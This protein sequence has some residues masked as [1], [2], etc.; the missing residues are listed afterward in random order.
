M[1]YVLLL[2]ALLALVGCLLDDWEEEVP[3]YTVHFNVIGN[4]KVLQSIGSDFYENEIEGDS[5]EIWEWHHPNNQPK[6]IFAADSGFT[7]DSVI[8]DGSTIGS[9]AYFE[10]DMEDH[11]PQRNITIHFGE[12]C[13]PKMRFI[14]AKGS[15]FTMG[16]T[17][18][19]QSVPLHEV[20][21][22]Y[23]FWM[24][25]TVITRKEYD[26]LIRAHYKEYRTYKTAVGTFLSAR[27]NWYSA[28]LYCNTRS[29]AAGLDTVYTFSSITGTIGL[30]LMLHD[31]E[32]DETIKGYRLP[33][34]GE[35]EYACR[36]GTT[37]SFFWGMDFEWYAPFDTIEVQRYTLWDQ[38]ELY[39]QGV[40]T[41]L[42]NDFG[43]YGM[44]F[45]G[46]WCNNIYTMYGADPQVGDTLIT[47]RGGAEIP[48]YCSGY[49]AGCSSDRYKG[50]RVVLQE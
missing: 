22:D 45:R 36:A 50:F 32:Y 26:E 21:F 34:E 38:P 46:E 33:L 35:W 30:D 49:R 13:V 20:S 15:S 18:F 7:V 12:Y 39:S 9:E 24:D 25:T 14:S 27:Q 4:G 28:V 48:T 41:K 47:L 37:T 17:N 2:V 5:L 16:D 10:F 1:K 8:V 42:P 40:A 43:L 19:E 23:N 31:V 6:V 29:K 3:L 44:P 11:P